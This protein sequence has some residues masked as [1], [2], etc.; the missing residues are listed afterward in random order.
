MKIFLTQF[1]KDFRANFTNLNAYVILGAYYILSLFTTIYLGD[2][3][4]RESD[5]M[6]SFFVMQPII[7]L[8]IIPAITMRSWAEEI[9]T[10]TIE[11]L[12]TQPISYLTIVLAKFFASYCFFVLLIL[13][14]I[15]LFIF[16]NL[17][18]MLDIG[19]VVSGYI[20]LL[21]CGALF[22]SIGCSISVFCKNNILSYIATIFMLF[23]ITQ[24]R[25]NLIGNLPINHLSFEDNFIAFLSGVLSLNNF[26]YFIIATILFIWL[27]VIGIHLRKATSNKD[28]FIFCYLVLTFSLIFIFTIVGVSTCFD[29]QFDITDEK[30]LTLSKETDNILKS[31][32]KRIDITLYESKNSRSNANSNY[33]VYAT[34]VEKIL[35]AFEKQS[36]GIIRVNVTLVEPFSSLERRLI[37]DGIVFDEDNLGYKRYIAMEFLDNEGNYNFIKSL[38]S[39][40]QNLLEADI[41]RIIKN[42]GNEKK[43]IGLFVHP[44]EKTLYSS[45]EG[46]LKEFYNVVYFD[47]IP[48][49]VDDSFDAL[50]IIK[51]KYF[52][53]ESLLTIEQYVLNGGSLLFLAEHNDLMSYS[54]EQ[55]VKFLST[56]GIYIVDEYINTNDF[57]LIPAISNFEHTSKDIRSVVIHNPGKIDLLEDKNYKIQ[58]ILNYENNSI[59]AISEGYFAS[60][61]TSIAKDYEAIIP[62][63]KKSG[64]VVF[65]NDT[66]FIKDYLTTSKESKSDYFYDIIPVTDNILFMQRLMS[67]I[68]NSKSEDMIRYHHYNLNFLSIGKA[69]INHINE[70]YKD[71]LQKLQNIIDENQKKRDDFYGVLHTK[72]F[73]SVKNIGDM[74]KIE[75]KI[76]ETTDELNRTKAM[77]GNDYKN[78]I[79]G[80]TII[81]ILVFPF[82]F[83]GIMFIV[84][85][86]LKTF[87]F[88]KI[89]RL[90]NNAKA[91]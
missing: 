81:L 17:V 41:V 66:D 67:Y 30:R 68:T 44:T 28:K 4:L 47:T 13:S 11:I 14:S 5:I 18:S 77:I 12:L 1:N 63:S 83:L 75:Q 58:S 55:I 10:G 65:F 56:F 53:T 87:K 91:S 9:K 51:P 45:F 38:H 2:Y 78:I 25:F 88:K 19:V 33:A 79:L 74:S 39:M 32:D 76:E 22:T 34:F 48:Y 3:F 43:K 62:F 86:V 57:P 64:R 85:L 49:F 59:S 82:I 80:L 71:T 50:I 20:G 54:G 31:I 61:H 69:I 24:I 42:F 7:L 90:I 23:F 27:N 70:R 60:N 46:M 72:K 35:R 52:S 26:V 29:K 16:S 73:A 37:N 89:G 15:L 21:L 40:R 84:L 8:F 36:N 6:N